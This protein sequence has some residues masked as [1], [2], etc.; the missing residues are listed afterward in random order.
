MDKTPQSPAV[1]QLQSSNPYAGLQA[2]A[3]RECG[4]RLVV[5]YDLT[6]CRPLLGETE[7]SMVQR[8]AAQI[9]EGDTESFRRAFDVVEPTSTNW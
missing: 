6:R 4:A 5:T 3:A 1:K 7:R 9:Q 2:E 8:L